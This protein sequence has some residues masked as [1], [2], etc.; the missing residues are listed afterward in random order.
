MIP[1]G[2]KERIFAL[3]WRQPIAQ[4]S[5]YEE[6]PLCEVNQPFIGCCN[7][8]H[9]VLKPLSSITDEDAI[10]YLKFSKQWEP[11]FELYRIRR[12]YGINSPDIKVR[13][14]Y[15]EK[16]LKINED[17][18]WYWNYFPDLKYCDFFRSKGYALPYMNYSIDELVN[19]GVFKIIET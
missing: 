2:V 17:G 4:D 19:E 14:L 1:Q 16:E 12:D 7:F 18:Y 9:L 8:Y 10:E 6:S 5:K 13:R 11:D 3:Y 15:R